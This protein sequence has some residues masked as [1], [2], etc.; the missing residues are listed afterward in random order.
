M[1]RSSS[2]PGDLHGRWDDDGRCD[3]GQGLGV[4]RLRSLRI[5]LGCW[6][7]GNGVWEEEEDGG[8]SSWLTWLK[9]LRRG[10]VG[11]CYGEKEGF[12]GWR[13]GTRAVKWWGIGGATGTKGRIVRIENYQSISELGF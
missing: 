4:E 8:V 6:R 3:R 5:R 2:I 12:V 10:T 9:W 13:A 7:D 11:V 1:I